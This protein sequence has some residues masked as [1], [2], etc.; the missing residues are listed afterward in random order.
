MMPNESQTESW[1]AIVARSSAEEIFLGFA[2][3]SDIKW[4]QDRLLEQK[5]GRELELLM[6]QRW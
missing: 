6:E 3:P 4:R 2:F 5:R 1:F